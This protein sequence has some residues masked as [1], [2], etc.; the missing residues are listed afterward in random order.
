MAKLAN[1]AMAGEFSDWQTLANGEFVN[2]RI[3][4]LAN[5]ANL[6]NVA[7]LTELLQKAN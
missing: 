6:A 3:Q 2:R 4:Q 5:L 1:L 7:D